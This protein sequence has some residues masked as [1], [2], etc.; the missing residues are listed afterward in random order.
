MHLKK[1]I[2]RVL[3]FLNVVWVHNLKY[4]STPAESSIKQWPRTQRL[5]YKSLWH[6][7]AKIYGLENKSKSKRNSKT[8][9]NVRTKVAQRPC[10]LDR[11][12][13]LCQVMLVLVTMFV[14]I[15]SSLPKTSYMKMVE[16]WLIVTLIIPYVETL[17]FTYKV[18]QGNLILLYLY[19]YTYIWF[20]TCKTA[21]YQSGPSTIQ[22]GRFIGS[23]LKFE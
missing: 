2:L 18:I 12:F 15:N 6:L 5:K 21:V 13:L 11:M 22:L 7:D 4:K 1:T 20:V 19:M 17:I 23:R 8:K 14:N 9:T 16:L 3:V 10:F